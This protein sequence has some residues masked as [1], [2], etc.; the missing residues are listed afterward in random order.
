M[1]QAVGLKTKNPNLKVLIAIGGWN[2]GSL[3][4]SDMARD[5]GKRA[6][7]VSS[8]VQ[9]IQDRKFDGLDMDWEYP[10]GRDGRPED[11]DNFVLLLQARSMNVL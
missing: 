11:K 6:T 2:Q 1:A 4:F 3:R 5:N 7:F 10:A 8:V 9:F